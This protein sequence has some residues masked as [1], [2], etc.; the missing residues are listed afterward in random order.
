MS[1]GDGMESILECIVPYTRGFLLL[2]PV[3]AGA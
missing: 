1:G 3:V 2:H